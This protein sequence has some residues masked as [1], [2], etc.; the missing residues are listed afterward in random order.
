MLPLKKRLIFAFCD[1]IFFGDI[2]VY[3]CVLSNLRH[4]YVRP[5]HTRR[6]KADAVAYLKSVDFSMLWGHQQ[7]LS[8]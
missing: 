6:L 1:Y 2:C 8:S 7:Y 4:A 5:R 3:H